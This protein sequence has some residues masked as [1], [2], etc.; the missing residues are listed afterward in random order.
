MSNEY[1]P[2]IQ[3]K[4]AIGDRVRTFS[5]AIGEISSLMPYSLVAPAYYVRIAG[6]IVALS[7]RSLEKIDSQEGE[8]V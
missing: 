7:E 3:H 5:G 1:L 6:R 8:T 2:P 4:F